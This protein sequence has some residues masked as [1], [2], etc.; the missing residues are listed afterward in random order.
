MKMPT[1][2]CR[3]FCSITDGDWK[4][5]HTEEDYSGSMFCDFDSN[6]SPAYINIKFTA[7]K[8]LQ[9]AS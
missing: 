8:Y 3:S 9:G 7:L 5:K 2:R 1:E 4:G 6:E